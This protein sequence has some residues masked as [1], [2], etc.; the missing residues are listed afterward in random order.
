M[1]VLLLRILTIIENAGGFDLAFKN[2]SIKNDLA[3]T[4]S[5]LAI[6]QVL[7]LRCA[8]RHIETISVIL[9]DF[10]PLLSDQRLVGSARHWALPSCE[11]AMV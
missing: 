11:C 3:E 2:Q 6:W 1:D 7:A 4:R 5:C 10:N 9:D 8:V